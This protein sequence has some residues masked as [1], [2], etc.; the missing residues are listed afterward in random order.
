[1]IVNNKCVVTINTGGRKI[2][3][4]T[5]KNVFSYRINLSILS[6]IQYIIMFMK[7]DEIS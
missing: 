6:R 7:L 2:D 5:M 4:L 3:I 1:M